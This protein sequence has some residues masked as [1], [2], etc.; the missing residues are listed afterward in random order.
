MIIYEINGLN[1]G[2]IASKDVINFIANQFRIVFCFQCIEE[3]QDVAK[4]QV[5]ILGITDTN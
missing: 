2:E 4:F 3:V 1:I 5:P